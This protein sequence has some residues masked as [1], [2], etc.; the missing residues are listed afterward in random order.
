[1]VVDGLV[2]GRTYKVRLKSLEEI[3]MTLPESLIFTGEKG[4]W[5]VEAEHHTTNSKGEG[6]YSWLSRYMDGGLGYAT[7]D[8]NDRNS[9]VWVKWDKDDDA[10]YYEWECL[11][12]LGEV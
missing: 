7:F 9:G 11:K 12:V 5:A 10:W 4:L 8:G 1:M 2:G 6:L 3:M